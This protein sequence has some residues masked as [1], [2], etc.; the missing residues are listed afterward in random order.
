[1]N[2]RAIAEPMLSWVVIPATGGPLRG[3]WW[4][5]Y[6]WSAYWR[7]GFEPGVTA[8]IESHLPPPGG[9]CWDIG[10]HFGYYALMMARHVGPEG[11]VLA[12]EP[13][14]AAFGR[15][16]RHRRLNRLSQLRCLCAAGNDQDGAGYL[17]NYE[18]QFS[19]TAH[20]RYA[21]ETGVKAT[22]H[23][24]RTIALDQLVATENLRP[25]ALIKVD[26]EGHAEAVIRGAIDTIGAHQP[27]LI[28]AIHYAAEFNGVHDALRPLGYH[29]QLLDYNASGFTAT[30][31]TGDYLFTPAGA[32]A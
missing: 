11:Q 17:L 4:S 8:A 27:T 9:V 21:G 24:V 28:I 6:P 13:N 5:L 30:P 26:V 1:M 16:D 19:T 12:L 29:P 20:F 22:G 10:A 18:D 25:P 31:E 2:W 32:N 7:G 15:L 3:L 14:P 23:R